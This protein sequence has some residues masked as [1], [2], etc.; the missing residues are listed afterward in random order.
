MDNLCADDDGATLQEE[1]EVAGEVEAAGEPPSLGHVQLRATLVGEGPHVENGD[2]EGHRVE[3]D[4]VADGPELGDRHAVR[5]RRRAPAAPRAPRLRLRPGD[6][7]DSGE[8]AQANQE[9]VPAATPSSSSSSA[10]RQAQLAQL[11]ELQARLDEQRRQTQEL[12]IALE[13]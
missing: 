11:K 10:A 3:G 4:A 7:E 5:P 1:G 9:V 6:D 13:Q 12:R 8:D 2:L